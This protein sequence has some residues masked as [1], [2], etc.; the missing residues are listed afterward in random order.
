MKKNFNWFLL[1]L[2][3]S[4]LSYGWLDSRKESATVQSQQRSPVKL[5]PPPPERTRNVEKSKISP[6][7][8][9]QT[10]QTIEPSQVKESSKHDADSAN[11]TPP[12]WPKDTVEFEVKEGR[13]AVGFGDI[14]LGLVPE[15]QKAKRA[16]FDPPRSRLWPSATIPFSIDDKT[17]NKD[18]IY[19]AIEYFNSQTPVKFVP[20]QGERDS[21]VFIP[22]KEICA[23]QLGHVGGHQAIL[24]S[25]ECG[26]REV[27]HELMHA[28]GFVHEHSREDRDR[29]VD[30]LWENILPEYW[31]QFQTVPED[32][33]HEYR[34]A[35]FDFDPHSIML[36]SS[37]A[38]AKAPGLTTLKSKGR[39]RLQP[40]Q[41]VLSRLDKERLYYLYGH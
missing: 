7:V 16:Y 17:P 2:A 15:E 41:D 1:F 9:Q 33:I 38:F 30:V 20:L 18:E 27:L 5:P 3:V 11:L 39:V 12:Q 6:E 35:V 40:S 8:A 28:L 37:T 23:S 13:Y 29:Y 14:V 19:A 36:Y 21:I 31:M 22:A 26:R 10:A 25:P 24:I 34:G 4:L 32:W